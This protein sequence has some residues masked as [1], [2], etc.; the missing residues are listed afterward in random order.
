MM[1]V[2]AWILSGIT[3]IFVVLFL[4]LY[5]NFG[6]KS[7]IETSIYLDTLPSDKRISMKQEIYRSEDGS[8]LG[9]FFVGINGDR[10]YW[11]GGSGLES[12]RLNPK[13][14]FSHY[15]FCTKKQAGGETI[16]KE[17]FFDKNEWL[18]VVKPGDTLSL[19]VL[20]DGSSGILEVFSYD[21]Y[22]FKPIS[23]NN[24][25]TK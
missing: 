10:L 5:F 21:F 25:C 11:W 23:G 24:L 15:S 18:K 9:G 7:Y 2:F 12:M 19:R 1:R 13:M 14:A 22:V 17:L 16:P 6:L 3:L 4:L 20:G 8:V